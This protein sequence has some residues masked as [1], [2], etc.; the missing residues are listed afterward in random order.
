MSKKCE[1]YFE[2]GYCRSIPPLDLVLIIAPGHRVR[3]T[4]LWERLSKE[5]EPIYEVSFPWNG[6]F[7]HLNIPTATVTITPLPL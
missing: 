7:L 5:G 2:H 4:I 3:G 6:V 1:L